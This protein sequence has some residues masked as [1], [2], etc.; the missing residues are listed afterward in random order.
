[1]GLFRCKNPVCVATGKPFE[2]ATNRCVSCKLLCPEIVAVHYIVPAEGPIRTGLGN[3]MIACMPNSA[4]MAHS[5]G[6]RPAVTCPKC[7]ASTIFQ[8][9][10]RDRVSNDIGT[11]WIDALT[12]VQ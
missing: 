5:S 2:A 9:D 10:E 4:A 3:R 1:M 7:V 12:Q 8:E 11:D 6:Y